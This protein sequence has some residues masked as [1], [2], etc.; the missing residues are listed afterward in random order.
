MG[1][2]KSS[3]TRSGGRKPRIFLVDDEPMLLEL[4]ER[5]L[6][7]FEFDIRTFTDPKAAVEA[8]A[9]SRPSPDLVV[10]DYA[11]AGL[12]GQDV[13][14]EARRINPQ[15]KIL[16]VSG[17]VD[18]SIFHDSPDKPDIFLAKPYLPHEFIAAVQSLL[19]T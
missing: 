2:L 5:I 12:N 17:T 19:A 1:S 3:D 10:T 16:L 11:M 8:L 7:S 4:G 15:Q 18:E 14:R 9:Q 13:I 6:E